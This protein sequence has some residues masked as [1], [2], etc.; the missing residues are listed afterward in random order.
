MKRI[1]YSLLTLSI[2]LSGI[3]CSGKKEE[4]SI[5]KESK[6]PFEAPE[7]PTFKVEDYT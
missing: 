2:M 1:F 3:A 5:L 4:N 7:F 6:A